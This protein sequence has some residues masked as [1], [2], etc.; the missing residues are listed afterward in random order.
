MIENDMENGYLEK[1][2]NSGEVMTLA[3]GPN[4]G[5]DVDQWDGSGNHRWHRW[6]KVLEEAKAEYDRWT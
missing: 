3:S 5:F 2:L 4:F 1:T 6:Y